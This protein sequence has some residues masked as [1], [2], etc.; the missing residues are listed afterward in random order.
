[1]TVYFL[2]RIEYREKWIK[3]YSNEFEMRYSGLVS[4]VIRNKEFYNDFIKYSALSRH[5]YCWSRSSSS[6]SSMGAHIW[7][8]LIFFSLLLLFKYHKI[9]NGLVFHL[10]YWRTT[11]THIFIT[12]SFQLVFFSFVWGNPFLYCDHFSVSLSL[13]FSM[14]YIEMIFHLKPQWK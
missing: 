12:P 1:M 3:M 8:S 10:I 6:A 13:P 9:S 7:G 14:L 11:Q 2:M 5:I 4:T